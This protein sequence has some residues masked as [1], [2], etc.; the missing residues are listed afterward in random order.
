MM[1]ARCWIM[2][3]ALSLTACA[4]HG[5]T[6]EPPED[7]P[8][9]EWDGPL[10]PEETVKTAER[11]EA[12]SAYANGEREAHGAIRR[13]EL[14]LRTFDLPPDCRDKYARL[15]WRKHRIAHLAIADCAVGMTL[16][17]RALGFNAVMEAEIGRRFGADTLAAA[18]RQAGCS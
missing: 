17:S 16:H 3:A 1:R 14:A 11:V 10:L 6:A 15:L 13:G 4:A 5:R 9:A 8:L 7:P 12:S 18:A 2:L